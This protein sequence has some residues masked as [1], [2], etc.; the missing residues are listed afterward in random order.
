MFSD[1]LFLVQSLFVIA[2]N[3]AFMICLKYF[4]NKGYQNLSAQY[5]LCF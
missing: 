1:V 5:V 3:V 2:D 4:K